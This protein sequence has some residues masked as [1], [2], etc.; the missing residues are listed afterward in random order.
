MQKLITEIAKK[1]IEVIAGESNMEEYKSYPLKL[2]Y[3]AIFIGM[4]GT[5]VVNVNFKNHLLKPNDIL[6]LSEDSITVFARTSKDFRLFYCL[7]DKN[8][9][10]EIA[11]NLPNHLFT[12]LWESPLCVP[13]RRE[14]PLLEMWRGQ[15][16]HIIH[17]CTTYRHIMLRNHLQNFFLKIAEKMPPNGFVKHEYSRKEKLCWR[18]WD[19]VGKHCKVHRD[20]AFYARELCITPFYLSQITKDF[21]NDSPKGLIDRQVIL[22]MKAMLASSD[23]SIK[24]MAEQLHFEDTSYMCRYFKRHIG[25]PLTE[26]RK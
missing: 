17:Q 14:T 24:E 23:I 6:V 18:F 5:A 13:E 7:I 15:T 2:P 16:L 1:E 19:L 25:I 3:L 21:M 4:K 20:V 26:Y 9:A 12:F 8:L 22:E 10:S 11:Y